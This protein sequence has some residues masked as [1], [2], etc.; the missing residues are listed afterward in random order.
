MATLDRP[1]LNQ[2]QHRELFRLTT[3]STLQQTYKRTFIAL[4]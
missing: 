4:V 1:E 2:T 3:T